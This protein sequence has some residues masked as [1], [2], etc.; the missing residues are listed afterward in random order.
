MGLLEM[1]SGNSFWRGY[2]YYESG[3][4]ISSIRIDDQKY[5][6]KVKGSGNNA[7]DVVLDLSHPKK[8]TCTCPHAEGTRRVCKHKVALFFSIFPEE[9]EKAKKEAEDWEFQEEKRRKEEYKEI[10]KY[11]KMLSKEELREEL[12]WRMIQE[13]ERRQW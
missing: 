1:A 5:Q 7:Y 4:V 9:A 10:E 2:D 3:E 6:G 12:I 13:R 11:V 8:S